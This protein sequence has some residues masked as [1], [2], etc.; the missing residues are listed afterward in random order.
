MLLS[1]AADDSPNASL[2]WWPTR[3]EVV[4]DNYY[5]LLEN[6]ECW[7]SG[8]LGT[9]TLAPSA[10]MT[11][12]WICSL[13][14]W[15]VHVCAHSFNKYLLCPRHYAGCHVGYKDSYDT[16]LS[17]RNLQYTTD[18]DLCHHWN[19]SLILLWLRGEYFHKSTRKFRTDF[20]MELACKQA[21][22]WRELLLLTICKCQD[23]SFHLL[24]RLFFFFFFW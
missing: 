20:K 14:N 17:S 11:Q 15:E 5:W 12:C 21:L 6:S 10:P 16:I 2:Y 23:F 13:Q 1:S 3:A 8:T 4:M 19:T 9:H 22:S 24:C 7:I 18:F